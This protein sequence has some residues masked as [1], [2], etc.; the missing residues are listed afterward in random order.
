MPSDI[1][2]KIAAAWFDRPY[3]EGDVEKELAVMLDAFGVGDAFEFC[4]Q[5]LDN[6]SMSIGCGRGCDCLPCTALRKA[7]MV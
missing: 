7:G 1:A 3:R 5:M 2:T 6:P 4:Q